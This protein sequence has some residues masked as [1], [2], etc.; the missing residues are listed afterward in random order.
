MVERP[1]GPPVSYAGKDEKGKTE[2]RVEQRGDRALPPPTSVPGDIHPV[3]E[4]ENGYK[5]RQRSLPV[6]AGRQ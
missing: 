1:R 2:K 6:S 3:D 5:L 4:V